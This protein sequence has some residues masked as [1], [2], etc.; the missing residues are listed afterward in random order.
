M[1]SPQCTCDEETEEHECPWQ[2]DVKNNYE[3][4]CSCCEACERECARDI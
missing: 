2:C 4:Y 3:P 1:P